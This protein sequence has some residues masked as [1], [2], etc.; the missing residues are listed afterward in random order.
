MYYEVLAYIALEFIPKGHDN[1]MR[2]EIL[3]AV[4]IL[5]LLFLRQYQAKWESGTAVSE[6]SA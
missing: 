4:N 6:K 5:V 3:T 1:S 2:S